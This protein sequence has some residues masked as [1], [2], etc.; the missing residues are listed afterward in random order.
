MTDT[1]IPRPGG[2]WTLAGTP[3]ARIGFGVMQLAER[4][5]RPA[6]PADDA[7]AIVRHAVDLGITHFDTAS[8]YGDGEANRRLREALVPYADRDDIVL[9]TKIGAVDDEAS[10]RLVP[11]QKPAEL[12][13]QVESNLAQL[14]VDRLGVVNLRRTDNAPGIIATGD[15]IVDLDD[16]LAELITLRDEGKLDG[17]GLSNVRLDQLQQALPAAIV[18]VQN[19]YNLL[20]REHED[21]LGLCAREGIAWVPY[22]PLGS[23]FDG[24]A[25]VADQRVVQDAA[26]ALGSTPAQIGLAWLLQHAPGILLITGTSNLDHLVE[27]VA[28]G[29]IR[30]DDEIVARLDELGRVG[31][32]A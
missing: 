18:C 11:A 17:I 4:G 1:T 16:Q 32:R 21:L 24:F 7:I 29:D 26:A 6:I 5:G 23:A 19:Y 30:L 14:G 20:N 8:F 2:T 3:V 13:A 31:A 10:A 27:N 28:A 9:A 12:R 15:Q 22:F 25:K